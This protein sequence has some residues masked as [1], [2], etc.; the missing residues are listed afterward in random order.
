MV[1]RLIRLDLLKIPS[2]EHLEIDIG[3]ERYHYERRHAYLYLS[4]QLSEKYRYIV[5]FPEPYKICDKSY[6]AEKQQQDD[7]DRDHYPQYRSL[8]LPFCQSLPS[9]FDPSPRGV[10]PIVRAAEL[11]IIPRRELHHEFLFGIHRINS[12]DSISSY[13]LSD[14]YIITIPCFSDLAYL[15]LLKISNPFSC[16]LKLLFHHTSCCPGL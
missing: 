15:Q 12:L 8:L 5:Q 16:P 13:G 11:Y 10:T 6:E 14:P 2:L 4:K 3:Q 7:S 9:F 1:H